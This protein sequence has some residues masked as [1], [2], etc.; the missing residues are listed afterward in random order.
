MKHS[1]EMQYRAAE[2][3]LWTHFRVKPTERFLTLQRPRARVRLIEVGEGNPLLFLHGGPNAGS[4]WAPLATHL[5]NFRCLIL[6]RPGCG[7]SEAISYSSVDLR[8]LAVDVIK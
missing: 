2:Q 8:S 5:Q 3:R 7:L 6:D 1:Q 4:T